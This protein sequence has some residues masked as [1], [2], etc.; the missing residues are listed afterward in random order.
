MLG[1]SN[2]AGICRYI[3]LQFSEVSLFQQSGPHIFHS[4]N[5]FCFQNEVTIKREK[6]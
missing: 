5:K 2:L 3:L 6:K 4:C 1:A